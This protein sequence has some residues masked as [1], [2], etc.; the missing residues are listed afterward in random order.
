[1]RLCDVVGCG[2]KHRAKGYCSTHYNSMVLDS[3]KRRPKVEMP[4][5]ACG[6]MVV[7]DKGRGKR[8][9]DIFCN[10]QC[11][12]D[13]TRRNRL[14]S[15]QVVGPLPWTDPPAPIV[16]PPTPAEVTRLWVNGPCGWCGEGFTSYS[17]YDIPTYCSVRCG[18]KSGRA[19]RR[20]LESGSSGTYT[21]AELVKKW[22]AVG[23][24]CTYCREP[25]TLDL[26]E[27]DHVVPLSK[28]G[29][30]SIAN[31]VP[32]CRGCNGDKRDLLIEDWLIDRVRRGL[33]PIHDDTFISWIA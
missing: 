22:I 18:R 19:R 25:H 10:L 28:G 8:Y 31:V 16:E 13:L 26:I 11:R 17:W 29:S 9:R 21:Q 7:K 2:G 32:S 4:C 27:P 3:S 1:M 15:Q 33:H 14:A 5:S 20:A 23:R 12:S 24:C 6:T 30:N